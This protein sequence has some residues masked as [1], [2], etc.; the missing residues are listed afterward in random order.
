LKSVDLAER[1]ISGSVASSFV[2]KTSAG[3]LFTYINETTSQFE[4]LLLHTATPEQV[5]RAEPWQAS[6]FKLLS[7]LEPI[8]LPPAVSSGGH[9][10]VIK[11]VALDDQASASEFVL[12]VAAHTRTLALLDSTSLQPVWSYESA[13]EFEPML[14]TRMISISHTSSQLNSTCFVVVVLNDQ[15]HRFEFTLVDKTSAPSE[16]VQVSE[17]ELVL[18]DRDLN[19]KASAPWVF[20]S[21]AYADGHVTST[22]FLIPPGTS[23]FELDLAYQPAFVHELQIEAVGTFKPHSA[24]QALGAPSTV[25][26][27][28]ECT[29]ASC[30]GGAQYPMY[31]VSNLLSEAAQ[32]M[33]ICF[34]F[35]AFFTTLLNY[36]V[37]MYSSVL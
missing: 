33:F 26:A 25:D 27:L 21:A 11:S 22:G 13:H 4:S 36:V 16:P 7:E 10:T 20:P 18:Q 5:L 31:R 12:M 19:F 24:P 15:L 23:Q 29:I 1:K 2:R 6:D 34:D 14:I 9:C 8:P 17:P 37:L 35:L 30:D 28:L 32:R 3:V